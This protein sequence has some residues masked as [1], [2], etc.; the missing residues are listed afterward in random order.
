MITIPLRFSSDHSI[1]TLAGTVVHINVTKFPQ[2]C[3][4]S[5]CV[6]YILVVDIVQLCFLM[7]AP[8]LKAGAWI[9]D[10]YTFVISAEYLLFF[11]L[12]N[13]YR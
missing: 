2:D 10:M 11:G 1:N 12:F 6:V 7:A 9:N 4:R 3:A 8:L 5:I 13:C